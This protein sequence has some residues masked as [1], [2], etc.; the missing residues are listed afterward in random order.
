MIPT[1]HYAAEEIRQG[2][3]APLD[4]VDACLERIEHYES[5]VHAWVL[6]DREGARREAERLT[7]ELRRGR[8]R[9]PLHGIPLGIKDIF[10]VFDWPTAAGSKQWSHS[11]ARSDATVVQRLRDA[12][13]VFL[14][15]TVTTQYASFDPPVTRNPWNSQRTPGGSSSGSAA[16]LACGMCLGA[17]GS[18]TGGSITRPAAY[19]GVT[20]CKPTFGRVSAAGVVP[21]A[22]SMDH[23][24]PMARC[25]RDLAILLQVIAGADPR[26]SSCSL[27]PVP[28]YEAL[29]TPF[30]KLLA[31]VARPLESP[32]SRLWPAP[33]V[34]RI[35]GLFDA[36]A[37]PATLAMMDAVLDVLRQDGAQVVDV[38]LPASFARVTASHRTLMA[39]EAAAFHQTRLEL[40]PED[41][42]PKIR[43]LLEEG[44]ATPAPAYARCKD[45]QKQL[46]REMLTCFKSASVLLTPATP[47][48]APDAATTGDPVFN[49]P[50]SFTG[51]PTV[52]LPS[53][54]FAEG[55]PLAIQLVG[56]PWREA[57]LLAAAAWCEEAL[58]VEKREPPG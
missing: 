14:G 34:G 20:G 46:T 26:D 4:L 38:V 18:Q 12:G 27:Q 40:H 44:L 32:L 10:D 9:G 57:E 45:H 58:G 8:W 39:V 47:G 15:K 19:C 21:L 41:Y 17:L 23:P 5:R 16:A 55:L 31:Q 33:R 49:S 6:I 37:E 1:I 24:G 25:V 56:P 2:R 43:G 13:A 7:E 29:L 36:Y 11:I 48:P 3:L 30:D 54:R 53:G 51:F 50:W 35:H 28:D 52:C 22:A 42:E